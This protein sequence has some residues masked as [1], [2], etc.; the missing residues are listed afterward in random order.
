MA[1]IGGD[2]CNPLLILTSLSLAT[3][4]TEVLMQ[5]ETAHSCLRGSMDQNGRGIVF[6]RDFCRWK[7]LKWVLKKQATDCCWLISLCHF[8]GNKYGLP[9]S[10]PPPY[11]H[12][13]AD[14]GWLMKFSP[15]HMQSEWQV[16]LGLLNA[17]GAAGGMH[18]L[19]DWLKCFGCSVRNL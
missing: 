3:T 16:D 14:S 18:Q 10:S 5:I 13:Q 17:S 7:R 11:N 2:A 8:R 4:F 1:P 9:G 6:P 19:I 12:Q 15:Y